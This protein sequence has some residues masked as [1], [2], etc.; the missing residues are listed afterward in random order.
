MGFNFCG[1]VNITL[2][3]V[4]SY[5]LL[6][7]RG[8]TRPHLTVCFTWRLFNSKKIGGGMRSSECDSSAAAVLAMPERGGAMEGPWR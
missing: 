5:P 7:S 6:V 4:E 1:C 2:R 3:R 8:M